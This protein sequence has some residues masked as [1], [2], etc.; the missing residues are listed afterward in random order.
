MQRWRKYKIAH[1]Q[2]FIHQ[3]NFRVDVDGDSEGQSH[4][5][6]AGISLDRLVDKIADLSELLNVP[7]PLVDLSVG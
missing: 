7:V 5:H 4:D 3:Q 6:A 1:G 2:R